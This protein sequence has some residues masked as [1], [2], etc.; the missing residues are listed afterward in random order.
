VVVA[1]LIAVAGLGT[2]AYVHLNLAS[3]YSEALAPISEG[4]LFRA[5]AVL[6]PVR[7]RAGAE[8][9]AGFLLLPIRPGL[10]PAGG[11]TRRPRSS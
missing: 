4:I 7:R 2:G 1:V 3:A 8:S 10:V 5:E 11:G 6:A 9:L